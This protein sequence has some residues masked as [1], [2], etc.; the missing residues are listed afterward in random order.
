MRV[1]LHFVLVL[2]YCSIVEKG[3]TIK[4]DSRSRRQVCSIRVMAAPPPIDSLPQ[5]APEAAP[6]TPQEKN[7]SPMTKGC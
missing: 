7:Q 1:L 3:D 5:P 2:W 6:P 4:I